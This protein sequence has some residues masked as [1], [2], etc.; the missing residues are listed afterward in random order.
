MSR[1]ICV[2]R[3]YTKDNPIVAYQLAQ[4]L[5]ALAVLDDAIHRRANFGYIRRIVDN[6]D[7]NAIA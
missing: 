1:N 2:G 3:V 6:D 7:G 5:D 4:F